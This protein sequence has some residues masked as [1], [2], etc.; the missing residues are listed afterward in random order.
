MTVILRATLLF[1]LSAMP[2]LASQQG[3][4]VREARVYIEPSASAEQAGIIEAGKQVA[5]FE[6]KGGWKEIYSEQLDLVGWVRSY[7]VREGDY[8]PPVDAAAES[9]SRGFLSGLA[10]FSRK[11]S[12][13]FGAGDSA[14]GSGT[15]TIGVRGLS[16]AEIRQARPD[17]REFARMQGFAS[18][19][20][21]LAEFRQQGRLSANEV[22]HIE[23]S[24]PQKTRDKRG[25]DK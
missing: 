16:E 7:Q 25:T 20:A 13:F 4:V 1:A 2:L 18:D 22:A 24:K 21:R 15:A 3:V 12:R 5:I 17:P 6:R 23:P 11:A 10:A 8:A 14:A 9:D 19:A